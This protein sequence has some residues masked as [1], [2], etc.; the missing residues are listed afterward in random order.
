MADI[1]LGRVHLVGAGPGDPRLLTV[2]AHDLVKRAGLI[3]HDDLVPAAILAVAGPQA[4]IANVGKRCG[5]KAIT[6]AEI[7]ARM[8]ESA[9]RGLDVVRLHGGDPAL[10][11]RLA[12]EM[13]ALEE[14]GIPFEIVPGVTAGTAAAAA[15]GFSLTDRRRSSRV[16]IVSGHRASKNSPE[17]R[18]NWKEVAREDT[19][20]I[21]Y[22]PGND[23]FLLREELLASGLSRDTP[24]V[25]VSRVGMPEQ[26]QRVATLADLDR[27][28]PMDTPTVLIIGRTI[29]RVSRLE[30]LHDTPL[31]IGSVSLLVSSL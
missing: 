28:P 11:G 4:E 30:Q 3:L 17:E 21:V 31:F 5:A 9:G 18:T 22:M 7:N 12:E 2:K 8:I 27:L 20:L 23:F 15:L 1:M 13:D 29:D 6:Q 25:L 16:I 19:T 24:A 14:A 10:F 26:Q